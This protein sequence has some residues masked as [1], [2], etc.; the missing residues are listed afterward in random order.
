MQR[1]SIRQRSKVRKDSWIVQIYLGVDPTSG[2]KRYRTVSV[3][4]TW[5]QAEHRLAEMLHEVDARI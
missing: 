3:R 1:G 2:K 5:A 4:G